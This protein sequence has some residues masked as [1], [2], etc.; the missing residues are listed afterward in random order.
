MSRAKEKE[1][2][3]SE[4]LKNTSFLFG[5]F[6]SSPNYLQAVEAFQQAA[7][8]YRLEKDDL[9]AIACFEKVA[10]CHEQLNSLYLGAKA[11]ETAAS[12]CKTPSKQSELYYRANELYILG[13]SPDRAC[14]MI[15]KAAQ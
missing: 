7:N 12:I 14:G 10:Y 13:M 15:E 8:L 9:K 1:E 6:G 3:G 5:L 2:K 4:L 11:I